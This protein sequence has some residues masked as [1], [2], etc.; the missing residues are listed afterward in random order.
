M[1]P[2]GLEAAEGVGDS[3]SLVESRFV[4]YGEVFVFSYHSGAASSLAAAAPSGCTLQNSNVLPS[5]SRVKTML[6]PSGAKIGSTSWPGPSLVSWRRNF[7]SSLYKYS[8][9]WLT[10]SPCK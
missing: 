1:T 2:A 7:P 5:F 3:L 8:R 4:K 6:S 9:E 10:P